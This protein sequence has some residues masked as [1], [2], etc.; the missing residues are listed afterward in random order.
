MGTFFSPVKWRSIAIYD[1]LHMRLA[2]A[3][4]KIYTEEGIKRPSAISKNNLMGKLFEFNGYVPRLGEET[5]ILRIPFIIKQ[6]DSSDAL[7]NTF[8]YTGETIDKLERMRFIC[9]EADDLH[10]GTP[11]TIDARYYY[12]W[13][14][15]YRILATGGPEGHVEIRYHLDYFLTYGIQT[16]NDGGPSL[17]YGNGHLLRG[18]KEFARPDPS[19]PRQ[20]IY[21]SDLKIADTYKWCIVQR[22]VNDS[23]GK[24]TKILTDFWPVGGTITIGGNAVDCPNLTDIY[25]GLIEERLEI[26]PE[27]IIGAWISPIQ[28]ITIYPY[29]QTKSD[30]NVTY[31]WYELDLTQT[32][33]NAFREY[34]GTLSANVLMTDD[35]GKWILT[36]P[37][38]GAQATIPWGLQ[39]DTVY[40]M[41][42]LGTTS[43][44]L[45]VHLGL[46]ADSGNASYCQGMDFTIPLESVPVTSNA[47]SSYNYSG[48]RDYDMETK[49]LQQEQ[50]LISGVLG[51]G[52]GAVGGAIAG[53]LS[54][55]GGG[56]GAIAGAGV[57]IGAAVGNYFVQGHYDRK[58]QEAVDKLMSNQTASVIMGA[59]GMGW[60][61]GR[62]MPH[63]WALVHLVRDYY[64]A[65]ELQEQQDILGYVTDLYYEG[66]NSLNGVSLDD[67]IRKTNWDPSTDPDYGVRIE[68]LEVRGVGPAAQKQIAALFD[69]GVHIDIVT[70]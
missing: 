4:E 38:G 50:A 47:T 12:G 23:D 40:C 62:N 6:A 41:V 16:R 15:D 48:Q 21:D 43:A 3:F 14:D 1:N 69:R 34:T 9:L 70:L 35:L 45:M 24:R 25:A 17:A 57:S 30:T 68:G 31:A 18:P 61:Y 67:L 39:F 29:A 56:M 63:E 42:D 28:P 51:A 66:G 36:D 58:N 60:K 53:G 55:A 13:V 33:N 54:S 32:V 37:Y 7:P 2:G 46:A 10:T 59:G 44:N 8:N 64:S 19:A 5:D 26:D 27:S 49:R 22:A 20:W 11:P 52:Q 65:N